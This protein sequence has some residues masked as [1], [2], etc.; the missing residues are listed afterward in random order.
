MTYDGF[1]S[2]GD[3]D[4]DAAIFYGVP[5]DHPAFRQQDDNE[6]D[7]RDDP[8]TDRFNGVNGPHGDNVIDF[9]VGRYDGFAGQDQQEMGGS[10]GV[11]EPGQRTADA[12]FLADRLDAS[13]RSIATRAIGQR[14]A[15]AH[16]GSTSEGEG[17]GASDEQPSLHDALAASLEQ[18]GVRFRDEW[19]GGSR[20]NT[21]VE[22]YVNASDEAKKNGGFRVS[23]QVT[24]PLTR[25]NRGVS[26]APKF[27]SAQMV[28]MMG[29][30]KSNVA[31]TW[32]LTLHIDNT[33][34]EE[35]TKLSMAHGLALDITIKR[36]NREQ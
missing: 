17:S 8:A 16:S 25:A 27:Q 36:K 31:G 4:S 24:V 9:P 7:D 5:S 23:D 33:S 19:V 11:D 35:V 21:A 14:N 3:S 12:R 1:D 30:L 28:G 2:G 20:D 22:A 18:A 26:E 32:V 10:L 15:I 6:D 34:F 13:R 29:G